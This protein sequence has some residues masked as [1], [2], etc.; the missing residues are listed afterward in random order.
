MA[1]WVV[2][3]NHSQLGEFEAA[4]EAQA[5][6]RPIGEAVGDARLQTLATWGVGIVRAAMG[7]W[8]AGIEACR[9]ALEGSPDPLNTALASGWLG[10]AYLEQGDAAQAIPL[11]EAAVLQF[12][13]YEFRPLEGWFTI[14]LAEA[15]LLKG[16][17][18]KARDL[19]L[20]GLPVA[21]GA[22]FIYA[23]GW[24]Q[25]ALGRIA[26]VSGTPSEAEGHF[27]EALGTFES[28]QARGGPAWTW[29]PSPA[30]RATTRRRRRTWPRPARSSRP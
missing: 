29:P 5:R 22:K 16:D 21:R 8:E 20:H 27:K 1:H 9:R 28:T 2:G 11:L 13:Q 6:A 3:M 24:A 14:F 10:Y 25:R 23:V 26:R 4:L 30:P 18:A 15:Y 12:G 17:I 19:S 7:D